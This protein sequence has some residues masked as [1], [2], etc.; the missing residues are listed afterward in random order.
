M[1]KRSY[2]GRRIFGTQTI[3]ANLLLFVALHAPENV[4]SVMAQCCTFRDGHGGPI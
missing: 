2:A 1:I 3:D 4:E